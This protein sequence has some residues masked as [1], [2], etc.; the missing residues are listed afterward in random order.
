MLCPPGL[1]ACARSFAR[2]QFFPNS[3]SP[4][5][6]EEACMPAAAAA[7]ANAGTAAPFTQYGGQR[8][9]CLVHTK[10]YEC[11]GA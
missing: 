6:M 9:L 3:P 1:R 7:A 10:A 5:R 4:H 8:I 2:S 11:V